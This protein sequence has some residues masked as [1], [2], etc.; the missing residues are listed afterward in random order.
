LSKPETIVKF[1]HAMKK[2]FGEIT[3]PLLFINGY[4]RVIRP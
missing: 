1:I 3:R 2:F 4:F